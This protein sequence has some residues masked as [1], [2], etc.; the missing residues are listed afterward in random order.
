MVAAM[1]RGLSALVLL[2]AC[3]PTP[4]TVAVWRDD[5]PDVTDVTDASDV[6]DVTD[7]TDARDVTDAMGDPFCAPLRAGAACRGALEATAFRHALCT[8]ATQA[9]SGA[10]VTDSFDSARGPYRTPARMGGAVGLNGTLA[11]SGRLDVGGDLTV[12]GAAALNALDVFTVRGR[13]RSA[14]AL[15]GTALATFADASFRGDVRARVLRVTGTLTLPEGRTVTADETLD[16]PTVRRADV[17]VAPPC[18]C[19]PT[20]RIPVA[21]RVDQHR[22]DNDNA[23]AN[24]APTALDGTSSLTLPCGRYWLQ[25]TRT[26]QSLALRIDGRVALYVDGDVNVETLAVT[27]A[28]GAELDLYLKGNLNVTRGLTLGDPAAPSRVRLYVAGI[29]GVSLDGDAVLAGNVYAPDVE[30]RLAGNATL[31]GAVLARA[32]S[33]A[34]DVAI[35]FDE[36]VLDPG[37]GCAS[38]TAC[39]SCRECPGLA[40]LDGR[41]AACRTDDDCCAPLR[42]ALGRCVAAP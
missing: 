5:A 32:V 34:G 35:H 15:A 20:T 25:P 21:A 42:C 16:A 18:D 26:A 1:L 8:C 29:G 11:L 3:S 2:A 10:L 9:F 30:L 41:C 7:V 33:N 31:Y 24:L 6:V 27:L 40:C 38:P 19:D 17:P 23:R 4:H 12:G 13:L 28:P 39:A 36:A 14:G 37:G 22:A